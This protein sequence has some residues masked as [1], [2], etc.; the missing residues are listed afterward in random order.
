MKPSLMAYRTDSMASFAIRSSL[1]TDFLRLL[2]RGNVGEQVPESQQVPVD[3]GEPGGKEPGGGGGE[4]GGGPGGGRRRAW[5]LSRWRMRAG[6]R[7]SVRTGVC[8]RPI[9]A[10]QQHKDQYNTGQPDWPP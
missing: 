9:H 3:E 10:R 4:P 7:Y 6:V 1:L 8:Q 2:I 5:S